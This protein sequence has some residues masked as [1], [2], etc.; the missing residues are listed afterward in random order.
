MLNNSKLKSVEKLSLFALTWPIFVESFLHMLMGSADTFMLAHVSDEAVAAVGVANQLIFMA[1]ILFGFVAQGTAVVVAQYLGAQKHAEASR[2]SA[3]SITI[4]LLMGIAISAVI[5][6]FRDQFLHLLKLPSHLVEY[7]GLYLNIVGGTVFVQALL[8][9]VSSIVRSNG[10]TRD[11]MFVSLGMNVVH[12]FGNYLFIYGAFGVPQMGV[13][14]VAIST[15]VSRALALVV[16]FVLMYRRLR[17][18]IAP[19]DYL[20]F[21]LQPIK[22]ILRIGIPGAGE[23]VSYQTSQIMITFFITMLG[24]AALATRVYALNI[25]FFIMLF[26]LSLGQGTQIIV[27]HKI[28]AGD[29]EGAYRQLLQSLKWSLLITIAVVTVVAFFRES[30]MGIFTK[31]TEIVAMGASLLLLCIVL[32]PGR[33]FNLVVIS[34]LRAAGD[35]QFPMLMGILSMWGISVPLSYYLG[36]HLQFGL[37]GIWMAFAADEWV[38]GIL[39]YLRW[40]SRAWEKN[41]LVEPERGGSSAAG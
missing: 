38:R 15:A 6:L 25:M 23:H 26:G 16:M 31:D 32:E 41:V 12:V 10:F 13:T 1:I 20:N 28:G 8:V 3:I 30:L 7:A 19:K 14:G 27:G 35:A 36:I 40:K 4:N 22:K 34:S 24:T 18:P 37:L 11:A 21:E 17:Y 33:T 9:T 2:V 29:K 5:V 39:M